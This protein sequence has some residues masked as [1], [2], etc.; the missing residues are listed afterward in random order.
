MKINQKT[1]N[2]K[3]LKWAPGQID[4]ELTLQCPLPFHFSIKSQRIQTQKMVNIS[5]ITWNIF[6]HLF[7]MDNN[8]AYTP[9][10]FAVVDSEIIPD[11]RN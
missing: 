11:H 8:T 3:Q 10:E 6:N 7:C 1:V 5:M 2:E 9:S 4:P